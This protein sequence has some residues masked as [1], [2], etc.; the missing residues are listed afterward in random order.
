MVLRWILAVVFLV[1]GVSASAARKPGLSYQFQC[2]PKVDQWLCDRQIAVVRKIVERQN[3]H[4]PAGWVW[5][6][7]SDSEWPALQQRYRLKHDYA[8]SHLGERRT[9]FNSLLFQQFDR[10]VWE[11][12]IADESA[13]VT[14]DL[15][16]EDATEEVA[17]ELAST[18]FMS[19]EKSCAKFTNEALSHGEKK[20]P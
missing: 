3:A 20:S 15:I 8:F 13:H 18:G 16:D 10:P 6:L 7:V 17:H 5:L 12:A 19:F 11:W 2:S 9:V 14:C 1:L 4:L